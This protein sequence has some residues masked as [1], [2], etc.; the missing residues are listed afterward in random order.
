[1]TTG[2]ERWRLEVTGQ[3][4]SGVDFTPRGDAVVAQWEDDKVWFWDSTTGQPLRQVPAVG[5][6][7]DWERHVA[8]MPDG[9]TAITQGPKDGV[10]LQDLDSGDILATFGDEHF[11]PNGFALSPDGSLLVTEERNN[12]LRFWNT[13]TGA[14]V[15]E[16]HRKETSA[17]DLRFSPDG[18]FLTLVNSKGQICLLDVARG[19]V[20][21]R[22]GDYARTW[23][24]FQFSPDGSLLAVMPRWDDR[25]TVH[26]WETG[27][28][29]RRFPFAGHENPISGLFFL[30]GSRL[31]LSAGSGEGFRLWDPLQAQEVSRFKEG[32]GPG[33]ACSRDG[34]LLALS[35]SGYLRVWD[36][37]SGTLLD[38]WDSHRGRR[39]R[40][41]R[42][43]RDDGGIVDAVFAPDGDRLLTARADCSIVAVDL[44]P[45]GTE[46]SLALGEGRHWW[47]HRSRVALS[48]DGRTGLIRNEIV[49]L[50]EGTP[51]P[52]EGLTPDSSPGKFSSDGRLLA[53]GHSDGHVGIWDVKSGRFLGSSPGVSSGVTTMGFS[54]DCHM[55]A[56]GHADGSVILWEVLRLRERHRFSGHRGAVTSL[57]FS[58]DRRLLASGGSD[59]TIL[60]W[61]VTAP[62]QSHST[63]R[64]SC[65]ADLGS[66]D[67]ERAYRALCSLIDWPD[68]VEWL[69]PRL[70]AV[71]PANSDFVR[72]LISQLDDERF[73]VRDQATK[74]LA[75]VVASAESFLRP[76][77][78]EDLSAEARSRIEVLLSRLAGEDWTASQLRQLRAVE[79]LEVIGSQE[80]QALLETLA[81]GLP[82][83]RLTREAQAARN[84]LADQ[85]RP[86]P[87]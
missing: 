13:R 63:D 77:L 9:Q 4:L 57:A 80:A 33:M 32:G 14:E 78:M 29:R 6:F 69:G 23:P 62:G 60:I 76:A 3:R 75:E 72:R 71:S 87:H 27:T 83:A 1:L 58:D 42:F 46:Q 15:R 25:T 70:S 36:T 79:L 10:F 2:K 16:R 82:Q 54:P 81:K 11:N 85:V 30:P 26:L 67:A 55:V 31:L 17:G 41:R 45:T 73:A 64:D 24:T 19:E 21:R 40:W 12:G 51:F 66:S 39:L 49:D 44:E 47:R 74:Q 48:P 43:G 28:G 56:T 61:D 34:R 37:T 35:S 68:A 22:F 52:L 38:G 86:W 50:P 59:S 8:L 65:W 20:V 53:V 18:R 5:P 84:R 7:L